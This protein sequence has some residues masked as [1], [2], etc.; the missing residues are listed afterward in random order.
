MRPWGNKYV[1]LRGCN[2]EICHAGEKTSFHSLTSLMLCWFVS[3]SHQL[4]DLTFSCYMYSFP[5]YD[6]S[7]DVDVLVK[8][9]FACPVGE[10]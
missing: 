4:V 7:I 8:E 2:F 1:S 10:K 6:L 9:I 5:V 3:T